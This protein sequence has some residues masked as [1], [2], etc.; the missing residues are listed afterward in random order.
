[1]RALLELS[2]GVHLAFFPLIGLTATLAAAIFQGAIG[3]RWLGWLSGLSSAACLVSVA[4]GS[5][6][7]NRPVPPV[8]L[9]G[10]FI[11]VIV[12]SV[13]MLRHPSA[14]SAAGLESRSATAAHQ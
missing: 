12:L 9:L 10:F 11:I 7:T 1:M 5:L 14:A 2:D 8:G 4:L 3:A 6:S 13:S